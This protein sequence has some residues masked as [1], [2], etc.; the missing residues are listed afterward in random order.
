MLIPLREALALCKDKASLPALLLSPWASPAP[1]EDLDGENL[2]NV[3]S[4]SWLISWGLPY[5]FGGSQMRRVKGNKS[6]SPILAKGPC[7]SLEGLLIPPLQ[8]P[9]LPG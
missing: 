8:T 5:G 1:A 7:P 3:L 6:P 2:S 9:V 4:D